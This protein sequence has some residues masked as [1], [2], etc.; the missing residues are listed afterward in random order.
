MSWPNAT[1]SLTPVNY[2]HEESE[3]DI[4]LEYKMTKIKIQ[5]TIHATQNNCKIIS[6]SSCGFC[7]NNFWLFY[8][9]APVGF[10]CRA[11]IIYILKG[12]MLALLHQK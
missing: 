11:K 3:N 9:F 6:A 5:H 12:C 8:Y 1:R 7:Q 10:P 2:E 4:N